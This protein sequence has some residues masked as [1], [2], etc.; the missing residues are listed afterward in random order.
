M[1][2]KTGAENHMGVTARIAAIEYHLPETVLTNNDLSEI[3][4]E[5]SPEKIFEKTGILERRIAAENETAADL[6]FYAAE[7][8]LSKNGIDH[9]SI[10]F[11]ILCTQAPDYKL[12]TSACLLQHRLKLPT[13]CG[14]VDMNLGC[15]GYVYGLALAKGLIE[16]G[17]RKNVLLLT[18]DTYSK[19]INPNDRSVRTL[20]GDGAAATLVSA[21][22]GV[23][24]KIGPF[25]LGTDGAGGENLIVPAGGAREPSNQKSSMEY[26]DSSGNRRSRDNLFMNGAEIMRFTLSAVPKAMKALLESAGKSVSDFD[27]V[28]FHQANGFMLDSLRKKMNIPKE[29]FLVELDTVGNTVSSTIPIA[30]ARAKEKHLIKAGDRALL[31]GFGVGYSW[32]GVV[33]ELF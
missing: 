9:N 13:D 29:K 7:K 11:L 2:G 20:F 25:V 30:I 1:I 8:L 10:D 17:I 6:A 23:E 33:V 16:G 27:H 21:A 32:G 26:A 3:F 31:M 24:Q 5:W 12:P 4:K 22:N 28:I 15:S 19:L 18:A 14:A